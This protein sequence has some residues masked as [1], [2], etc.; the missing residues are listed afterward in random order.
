[1]AMSMA[2][3]INIT[4]KSIEEILK[5]L[6]QSGNPGIIML[7]CIV[8]GFVIG[9]VLIWLYC[10]KIRQYKLQ[11]EL[12]DAKAELNQVKHDCEEYKAKYE[13]AKELA[14]HYRDMEYAQLAIRSSPMPLPPESD[15]YT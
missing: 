5:E 10:T 12:T 11:N 6:F 2:M 8:V 4:D 1:M 15:I 14:D 3:S 7:A 13:Q 9:A